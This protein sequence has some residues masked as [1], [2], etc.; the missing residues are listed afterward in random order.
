MA[1]TRGFDE[2]LV[3]RQASEADADFV[4]GLVESLLEHGSPTWHSTDSLAPGFREVLRSAVRNQGSRSTV[5]IAE[6]NATPLGF[7]S[8]KVTSVIGGVERAHVADL[9]VT[10]NARRK[11]VGSALLKAGEAW[12]DERG[13]RT[14]SL[15]VWAT[16]Q[17]ALDFYASRGY[18][19]ESACLI[20]PIG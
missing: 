19:T 8:L 3:I 16:N 4:A 18:I 11:G 12:A 5:L 14:L 6:V 13:L 1:A 7:I 10:E 9:A 17:S 2:Q 15:D 20:K